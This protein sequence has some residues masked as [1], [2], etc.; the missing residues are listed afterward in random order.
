[1]NWTAFANPEVSESPEAEGFTYATRLCAENVLQELIGTCSGALLV[2][3]RAKAQSWKISRRVVAE[4]EW[5]PGVSS[6]WLLRDHPVT[7]ADV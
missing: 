2:A 7:P 5:H 3:F 4:A 1:L 6:R